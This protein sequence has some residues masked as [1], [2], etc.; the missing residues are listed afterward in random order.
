MGRTLFDCGKIDAF[1]PLGS[2]VDPSGQDGDLVRRESFAVGRHLQVGVFIRDE[3]DERA[4]G[5]LSGDDARPV[6]IAPLER[7]GTNVQPQAA[8]LVVFAVTLVAVL[9][10]DRTDV[11][12]VVD[13]GSVF[14]GER[15]RGDDQRHQQERAE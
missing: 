2:G 11:A 12:D 7:L 14:S 9:L 6:Q 3:L 15:C 5:R 4:L 8:A 1:G 13:R 10:Q